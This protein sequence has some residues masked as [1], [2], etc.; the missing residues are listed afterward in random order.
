MWRLLCV[1]AVASLTAAAPNGGSRH[2]DA[3]V[4]RDLNEI[5]AGLY[6]RNI[7]AVKSV[8]LT[9]AGSSNLSGDEVDEILEGVNGIVNDTLEPSVN[10]D[11][12]IAQDQMD[13]FYE[14]FIKCEEDQLHAFNRSVK[15][16]A[17]TVQLTSEHELC[18]KQ[19]SLLSDQVTSCATLLSAAESIE[20]AKCTLY[21]ETDVL[22]TAP[23]C[24]SHGGEEV[25]AYHER[26]I[27]E[28]EASLGNLLMRKHECGNA[29]ERLL[30]QRAQCTNRTSEL[31]DLKGQCDFKQLKLDNSVC[32]LAAKM[33]IDCAAYNTCRQ[34][35]MYSFME[36]NSSVSITEAELQMTWKMLQQVRCMVDAA[37]S[38]DP[39][40]VAICSE[41]KNYSV[42]HLTINY[43]G[44]P[45]FAP[46]Q[47]LSEAPGS[48]EYMESLYGDLPKNVNVTACQ[49]S[50]CL[51][52]ATNAR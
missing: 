47:S 41:R 37:K 52:N 50:C 39:H 42:A 7:T 28:F 33:G 24:M 51:G 31:S 12:S 21:R 13:G 36:A 22:P 29:T 5:E 25:E 35:A 18:R 44:V 1:V 4:L 14:L 43:T 15:D 20:S 34:Q 6:A 16:Q 32:D 26:Q 27:K 48:P 19:Q 17:V 38:R 11:F 46:C 2:V 9:V 23:P 3:G 40:L 30:A 49:A 8:L 45:P 10:L